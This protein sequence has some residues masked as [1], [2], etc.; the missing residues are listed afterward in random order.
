MTR[1]SITPSVSNSGGGWTGMSLKDAAV[2]LL[3]VR[4]RYR[5]TRQKPQNK[6][7]R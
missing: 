7:L 6:R 5:L 3:A 1:N 2:M 4:D